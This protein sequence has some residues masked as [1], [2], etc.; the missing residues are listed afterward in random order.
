MASKP[1]PPIEVTCPCCQATLKVAAQLAVV[2]SHQAA[3]V[4]GP[5]VDLTDAGRL[6]RE[7]AERREEKFKKSWDA[8]QKKDDVLSRKFEEALKK[9]NKEPIEKPLR[10]FDID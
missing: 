7:Q 8:E 4:A 10:D 5:D 6:L 3:P 2:L 1:E 9:A